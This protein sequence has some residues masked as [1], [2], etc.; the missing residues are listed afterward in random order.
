[1][2]YLVVNKILD[3]MIND[4]RIIDISLNVISLKKGIIIDKNCQ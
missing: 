1:M 2:N 3:K 4:T